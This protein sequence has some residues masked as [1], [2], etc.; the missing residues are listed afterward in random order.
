MKKKKQQ[1][2]VQK[3]KASKQHMHCVLGVQI[4]SRAGCE[5]TDTR[6]QLV[7]IFFMPTASH[8]AA[9]HDTLEVSYVTGKLV[10]LR[11]GREQR[12]S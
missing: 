5:G 8:V 4:V 6:G 9:L 1:N 7:H 11:S 3:H 2:K 12:S 10:K